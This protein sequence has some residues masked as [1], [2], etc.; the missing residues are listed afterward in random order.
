MYDPT[1][2]R[3]SCRECFLLDGSRAPPHYYNRSTWAKEKYDAVM[4]YLNQIF[5]PSDIAF[6]PFPYFNISDDQ[7]YNIFVAKVFAPIKVG[8]RVP[9]KI[10]NT[11]IQNLRQ[12]AFLGNK[13]FM[14]NPSCF[15]GQF[16]KLAPSYVSGNFTSNQ[17]A[18]N[19]NTVQYAP[20]GSSLI[21]TSNLPG[22]RR[23]T[24]PADTS[25]LPCPPLYGTGAQL[26][27][28]FTHFAWANA[29]IG[30]KW[31]MS[32]PAY[33]LDERWPDGGVNG[34]YPNDMAVYGS[35]AGKRILPGCEPIAC[36]PTFKV[37]NGMGSIRIQVRFSSSGFFCLIG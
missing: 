21:I 7:Q 13:R 11:N 19:S 15:D 35:L 26:S 20:D 22:F 31:G 25:T 1:A 9:Y 18:I 24:D 2:T 14:F 34:S 36:L 29:S 6:Q 23:S 33:C 16:I 37:L 10:F 12:L 28:T 3:E 27:T 17:Q 5:T 4:A 32:L 8:Q 30:F